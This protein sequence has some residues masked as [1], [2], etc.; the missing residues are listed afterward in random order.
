MSRDKQIEIPE[1]EKGM[2]GYS[3]FAWKL[4]EEGLCNISEA[5]QADQIMREMGY[6][7]ASEV[8]REIF[9]DLKRCKP[10][11]AYDELIALKKKYLGENNNG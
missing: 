5:E 4:W 11:M 9:E 8:A 1:S 10:V 7:K 3:T 6:R 2:S